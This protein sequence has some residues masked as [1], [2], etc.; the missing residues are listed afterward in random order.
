MTDAKKANA[1]KAK[2]VYFQ[3][4]I[5][6]DEQRRISLIKRSILNRRLAWGN[7][8]WA[9][10]AT[11]TVA[12]LVPLHSFIPVIVRVNEMT[13]AYDVSVSWRN[14]NMQDPVWEKTKITDLTRYVNA[15]QGFTRG[16]AER[17]YAQVYL[18]S[19]GQERANWDNFYRPETNPNAPIKTYGMNDEDRVVIKNIT[20]LPTD[21]EDIQTAQV[22][23]DQTKVRGMAV[24]LTTRYIATIEFS[25]NKENVPTEISQMQYNAFGICVNRWR[26]D[27][28]G[29]SRQ[30]TQ[31]VPQGSEEM[32]VVTGS[33]TVQQV[34]TEPA[35]LAPAQPAAPQAATGGRVASG[36]VTPANIGTQG[37]QQ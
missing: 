18:M 12:V 35:Q 17:N 21:R 14:V 16:E 33:S 19:C 31:G 10:V 27:Q 23:Y 4:A 6:W 30:E 2:D 7:G 36:V 11:A 15:R 32:P 28:E 5:D 24:P 29:E 1:G 26:R 3:Q 22:R 37:G 8:I 34:T 20:F 25:Y 13:G 9:M